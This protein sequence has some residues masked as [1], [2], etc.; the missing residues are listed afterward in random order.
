MPDVTDNPENFK[1]ARDRAAVVA[2]AVVAIIHDWVRE[3]ELRLR[4]AAYLRQEFRDLVAQVF[5]ENRTDM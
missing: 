4:I 2:T 1:F 3:D 5:S